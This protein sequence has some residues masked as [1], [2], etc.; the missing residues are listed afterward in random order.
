MTSSPYNSSLRLW[1]SLRPFGLNADPA[2][3]S[4]SKGQ[5]CEDGTKHKNEERWRLMMTHGTFG[6]IIG[7]FEKKRMRQQCCLYF[8]DSGLELFVLVSDMILQ[9]V[10]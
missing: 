10:E 3:S 7:L 1:W 2:I 6:I 5:N 9:L 4:I 8:S